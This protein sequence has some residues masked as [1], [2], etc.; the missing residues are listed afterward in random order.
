MMDEGTR[1]EG[2]IAHF[3]RW[4]EGRKVK[5]RDVASIVSVSEANGRPSD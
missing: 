4:D 2:T 3:V 5:V 1:D